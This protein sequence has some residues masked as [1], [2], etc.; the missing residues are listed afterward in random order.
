MWNLVFTDSKMCSGQLRD[1]HGPVYPP[2]ESGRV[3]NFRNL[4]FAM[5]EIY[6][7]IVIQ[8]VLNVHLKLK[9]SKRLSR[10]VNISEY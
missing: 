4:F 10:N 1:F 6:L 3:G 8:T 2:V 5:V 7:L 9:P